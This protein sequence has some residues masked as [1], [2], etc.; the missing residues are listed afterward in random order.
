MTVLARHISSIESLLAPEVAGTVAAV[1]GLSILVNDLR[2]PVGTMVRLGQMRG[3]VVGFDGPRS[4]VMLFDPADGIAP[5]MPVVA[6]PWGQCVPVGHALLG[7]VVDALGKTI[8]DKPAPLDLA[9]RPVTPAPIGA[10]RRTRI[11]EPL[12]TGVRAID[13][14][15][16]IGKGQRVGVFSGAGVGK[17]TLLAN[18]ARN[19][20]ADVNV[21]ALVGER[22]R[23]VGDFIEEALSPEARARSVLVVA[24]SDESPVRRVRAAAVAATIAEFFRDEG[25]DVMLLM[26]SIT[27]FAQA[28]RQIGLTVGEQPATKGYT[29]SV[30][31]MLPMLLE[32]AGAV[33]G[34]GSITGLYAV[35]VEGDDLNEPI[36]DAARGVL[37]G[38]IVLSRKLATRAHYPAIDVRESISR[39]AEDITDPVHR[40]ARRMIVR[41][42]ASYAEAEDLI[43]IGAYAR[44][45]NIETDVAIELK[46]AIDLFLQQREHDAAPYPQTCKLLGELAAQAARALQTRRAAPEAQQPKGRK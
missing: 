28:Q 20:S 26:D 2:V 40:E 12:V 6:E 25:A 27:R 7:R 5:G 43:N 15:L 11:R 8:D 17:S 44:G 24:T 21:I 9:L 33:E 30:F 37:D 46:P 38:H 45:S 41:L 39:L 16:T 31:A 1:R 34:A 32:R 42:L 3:E 36:S 18:I 23:E 35:L 13:A 4:I 22:G 29:P 10:L 19:T 14:M